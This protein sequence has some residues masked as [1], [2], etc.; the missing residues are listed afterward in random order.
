M[1]NIRV[2]VQWQKTTVFAGEEVECI[3]TFKNTAP[4]RN[5]SRSTSPNAPARRLGQLR[6]GRKLLTPKQHALEVTSNAK[7][8]PSGT[9]RAREHGHRSTLSLNNTIGAPRGTSNPLPGKLHGDSESAERRHKRSVSIISISHD[10]AGEKAALAG[11]AQI[12]ATQPPVRH[13]ERSASFQDVSRKARAVHTASSEPSNALGI[14]PESSVPGTSTVPFQLSRSSTNYTGPPLR[15]RTGSGQGSLISN[16]LISRDLSA[17]V[18]SSP[19]FKFPRSSSTVGG[20]H[21]TFTLNASN[22]FSNQ[23][24]DGDAFARGP[25]RPFPRVLSPIS[26]AGTPRSSVDLYTVSN[27][28]TETLASEYVSSSFTRQTPRNG[29]ARQPSHLSPIPSHARPPETLMMGYAQL[30][31]SFTLDGSLVNLS[32]FESVKRKGVI[33][34]QGS[35]GVVGVESPKKE[36]GLFGSFGLGS[37]GESLGGLLGGPELSSI[38]EM[39]GIAS[40][41]SVPILSTPQAIL[42]VDLQLRPGESKSFKYSHAL[43]RGIPPS[44]KGRALKVVYQL[45]IGTQRA[46]ATAQQHVVKQVEVPFRVLAGVNGNGDILGHDLMQPHIMLKNIARSEPLEHDVGT[47]KKESKLYPAKEANPSPDDFISYVESL[48]DNSRRNSSLGLLSPTEPITPGSRLAVV[49]DDMS[50]RDLI[51][52]A[53]LRGNMPAS[54]RSVNRFQIQRAGQQVAVIGLAR[55]VYR[56]GESI[57]AIIDFQD[58]RIPCYTLNVSLETSEIIDPS[59]A[60]RSSSSIHRATRRVYASSTEDITFAQKAVFTAMIPTNVAPEFLTSGIQFQW[61]LHF[62]FVTGRYDEEIFQDEELLEEVMNDDK[63]RTLAAVQTLPCET[64]DVD[65]PIRVYG[66]VTAS[67]DDDSAHEYPI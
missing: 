16:D 2:S 7:A 23:Q 47:I 6:D 18:S 30:M 11:N 21:G 29:H 35:G 1:S 4:I 44:H 38:R 45:V 65:V 12:S 52:F 53:I 37:I 55:P 15:P 9:I 27:N 8:A 25:S 57:F 19:S 48:L 10:G 59:L 22:A 20:V 43:P 34:G 42:F 54:K 58:A 56:L 31:G 63:G 40:T 36:S 41:N 64:F 39:K 13:H 5:Y 24:N 26:A 33:G 62:E 51:D 46:Q 66:A 67:D 60:L 14:L 28:S 17:S 32:P 50:M 3:I 49:N 61:R